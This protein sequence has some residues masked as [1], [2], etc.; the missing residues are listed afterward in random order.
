MQDNMLD[1]DEEQP[2]FFCDE[3]NGDIYKGDS[4]YRIDG[5]KICYD[6]LHDYFNWCKE[7]AEQEDFND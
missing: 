6:C 1:T 7:D 5:D 4:I 2:L 3:C